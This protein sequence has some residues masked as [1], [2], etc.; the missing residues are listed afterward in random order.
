[1]NG[2]TRS[3]LKTLLQAIPPG[4]LVDTAWTKRHAISRQSVSAYVARGW[5]ERVA[6]GVYRRPFTDTERTE[7][8]NGWKIPL[9]S[10]QWLMRHDFHVGGASALSLRGHAHY[11]QLGSDPVIYLYGADVPA[12]LL[13]LR[14]DARFV[15]RSDTLFGPQPV[16][17]EDAAFS[18]SDNDDS[19]LALSPWRWPIRMSSPERAVL[20]TLDELPANESFQTVDK[21]FEN[22]VSLRP[23]A[24]NQLLEQ[25]R[26]IKVK[27]LF[28]IYA[29]KHAHPWRKH[30]DT[31]HIDLGRGDRSLL[32]GGRLHPTYRMT[33]PA[34]LVP[35]ETVDGT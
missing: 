27:R 22:L 35:Q 29:D 24:L 33:V 18:L 1:M 14:V 6:Q 21:L 11:L 12:W 25:C 26:S 20:E 9:L 28:F 8:V 5:L 19:E 31:A 30:V 16:G 32:Q 7:A 3:K 10:A 13:N 4:F 23:K 34:E 2:Q 15:H 17:V